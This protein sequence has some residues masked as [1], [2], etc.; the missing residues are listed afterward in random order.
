MS[1]KI[2]VIYIT[3]L[4]NTAKR[5]QRI[6][7]KLWSLYGVVPYFFDVKWGDNEV[8]E[9]KLERLL[10]M[11]DKFHQAGKPVALVGISAGASAA[12]NAYAARRGKLVGLVLICGWVNRPGDIDSRHNRENP[13]FVTSA[14]QSPQSLSA[15]TPK[16]RRRILSRFAWKDGIVSRAASY[17]PGGRNQLLPTAGHFFTIAIQ[18]IFGAPSFIRFLKK[19][20]KAPR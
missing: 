13:A 7:S 10:A 2:Q 4:G 5:G 15:L 12:V 17:I 18:I 11:V 6:A 9:R 14:H 3:G 16:D 20:P 19:Q 8:W 1:K